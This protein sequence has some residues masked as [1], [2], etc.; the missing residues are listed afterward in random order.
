MRSS[1]LIACAGAALFITVCAWNPKPGATEAAVTIE[2]L[3][4]G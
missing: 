2:R 1:R 4:C 3:S